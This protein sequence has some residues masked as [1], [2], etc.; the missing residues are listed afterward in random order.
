MP[1]QQ[2]RPNIIRRQAFQ[3]G[4]LFDQNG[5]QT[6]LQIQQRSHQLLPALF[7]GCG[8]QTQNGY[9]RRHRLDLHGNGQ[10]LLAQLL[11]FFNLPVHLALIRPA[12]PAFDKAPE[13]LQ[14][15]QGLSAIRIGKGRSP[16]KRLRR[17][18]V[19]SHSRVR[20]C[21]STS[22]GNSPHRFI[23]CCLAA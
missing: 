3:N 19:F 18:S 15:G 20:N 5:R 17:F 7:S 1:T 21:P 2:T 8:F 12:L 9:Q 22:S 16:L 23:T 11:E 10:R 13:M 6:G 4:Q 14:I